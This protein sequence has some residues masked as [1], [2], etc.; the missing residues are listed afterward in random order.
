MAQQ[1]PSR[2]DLRLVVDAILSCDTLTT[3][4]IELTN[5]F[6][7][8][9]LIRST[10]LA[11]A[12]KQVLRV[13][14]TCRRPY[15]LKDIESTPT[16]HRLFPT[17]SIWLFS[18]PP[19]DITRSVIL[20]HHSYTIMYNPLGT[21]D[22]YLPPQEDHSPRVFKFNTILLY[23]LI[24]CMCALTNHIPRATSPDIQSMHQLICWITDFET[25][26]RSPPNM[27]GPRTPYLYTQCMY[28]TST[29]PE[30]INILNVSS[31]PAAF[32]DAL[33][34]AHSVLMPLIGTHKRRE[35]TLTYS[36]DYVCSHTESIRVRRSELCDSH[37]RIAIDITNQ[38]SLHPDEAS[39]TRTSPY[40]KRVAT[41][42]AKLPVEIRARILTEVLTS[43]SP[44]RSSNRTPLHEPKQPHTF[45]RTAHIPIGSPLRKKS[46][47]YVELFVHVRY[48]RSH[49]CFNLP[50]HNAYITCLPTMKMYHYPPYSHPLDA[51]PALRPDPP[52]PLPETRQHVCDGHQSIY[53][54]L[55]WF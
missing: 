41:N 44:P 15:T 42:I 55:N 10:F 43:C 53:D 19:I 40:L 22:F 18:A 14:E 7:S 1:I 48:Q 20:A 11:T 29:H 9:P 54:Q 13:P 25:I 17:V 32:S 47:V 35:H 49:D 46:P 2:T 27:D 23:T 28:G 39:L 30:S 34:A 26:A 31:S 51:R 16:F 37:F 50:S 52:F 4:L 5:Y 38:F 21:I 6:D 24:S 3:A 45:T 12:T 36:C 33:H 8:C